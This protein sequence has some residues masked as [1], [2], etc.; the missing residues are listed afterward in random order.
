MTVDFDIAILGSGFGGSLL[1]SILA[2]QGKRCL[3]VDRSAHPRF[4]IGE[5]STPLADFVLSDLARRYEL[6]DVL[7]LASFGTWR[8]SYPLLRCGL[9]RGFSYFAH[10]P[11]ENFRTDANHSGQ[12]LV[13][14]SSDDNDSDTHWHRADVDAFLFRVAQRGG[15]ECLE[16][17]RVTT[18]HRELQTHSRAIYGHFEG[19][20]QFAD[21]LA[22]GGCDLTPHPFPCDHAALH[23]L[24]EHAWMWNL[25][26]VDSTV[27]AGLVLD[28]SSG[29]EPH[30]A[31]EEQWQATLRA[32]P[33]LAAQFA[34]A[35]VLPESGLRS[36]G[37]LQRL[38]AQAAGPGWAALPHTAGF[39]DPLHST[40]IAHTLSA[41]ERL[42]LLLEP[43]GSP[44]ATA[45]QA[46]SVAVRDELRFVDQLVS[47]C[48]AA[49]PVFRLFQ[50]WTMLYF[51]AAHSCELRRI[52]GEK[53]FANGFLG[54]ALPG[55]RSIPQALAPQLAA[56]LRRPEPAVLDALEQ[57]MADAI[58]PF[59]L[60]GLCDAAARVSW[61]F[62]QKRNRRRWQTRPH[63]RAAGFF[64]RPGV[65]R[66]RSV[67]FDILLQPLQLSSQHA[68]DGG[69]PLFEVALTRRQEPGHVVCHGQPGPLVCR[70]ERQRQRSGRCVLLQRPHRAAQ[71][72][73]LVRPQLDEREVLH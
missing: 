46:Y 56:A 15:V 49:L 31:A 63:C 24:L 57:N 28:I 40:G 50:A 68:V 16:N 51:A 10:Q 67:V 47:G 65:W 69:S 59:N 58:A 18:I 32:Y 12:L 53:A 52:D 64:E 39:V 3:L 11:G 19:V 13:A 27:S 9:K 22:D 35:R 33:S 55:L 70:F 48:Y 36:T 17:T 42:A 26:F 37:R 71:P 23:H 34:D 73:Q 54:A 4:T 6:T 20:R 2:R 66:W 29:A 43:P 72:Q 44:N 7:P 8:R 60:A 5:S 45:L 41:I 30:A 38:S 21:I 61:D 14:A 62:E 25:R 1:A